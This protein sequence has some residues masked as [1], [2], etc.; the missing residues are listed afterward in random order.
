MSRWHRL[1]RPSDNAWIKTDLGWHSTVRRVA[2]N[3]VVPPGEVWVLDGVTVQGTVTVERGATLQA[4]NVLISGRVECSIDSTVTLTASTVNGSLL[5][6]PRV[7]HPTPEQPD[8]RR[9]HDDQLRG[10]VRLNATT[11]QADIR[12]VARSDADGPRPQLVLV[13]GTIVRG[14]VL[15]AGVDVDRR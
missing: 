3:L 12:C 11:V 8:P 5:S 10:Q 15:V 14:C 4:T 2:G 1:T 9:A 6:T 7:C 13:G